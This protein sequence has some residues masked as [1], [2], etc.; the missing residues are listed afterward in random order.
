MAPSQVDRHA[1]PGSADTEPESDGRPKHVE[2]PGF[3]AMM[4]SLRPGDVIVV[5]RLD[6]LGRTAKGLTSLFAELTEKGINLVSLKKWLDLS[7]P[8]GHVWVSQKPSP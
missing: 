7:S 4:K 3:S 2:R 1:S 8:T 5:W 6:R